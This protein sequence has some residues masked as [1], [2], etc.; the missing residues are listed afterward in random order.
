MKHPT[1]YQRIV[2]AAEAGRG[3]RLTAAETR[4][5]SN[6]DAVSKLASNDDEAERHGC[7]SADLRDCAPCDGMVGPKT[8]AACGFGRCPFK[9]TAK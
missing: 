5:M 8:I 9:V 1:P 3:V 2:R 6:D 4:A 7:H